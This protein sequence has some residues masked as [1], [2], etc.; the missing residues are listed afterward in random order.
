MTD[1]LKV[2]IIDDDEVDRLS[3]AR[4][5]K[6]ADLSIALVQARS[7]SEGLAAAAR[8]RFDVILLDF[9]LPDQDGLEVL[10]ILRETIDKNAT[11]L[12]LSNME[13][14]ELVQKAIDAGAQD[15]LL[16]D[17]VTTRRLM[18]AVRQSQHRRRLEE[19]LSRVR[20]DLRELAEQDAL[21]GLANRYDFE[22]ALAFSVA[23]GQRD[24]G[25][26]A[27]L[28]LDV[29][30]FKTVND[31]FGHAVGDQLLIEVA[32]RLSTV[33]RDSDLLARLG[34]D[35]F[36]ILA[37]DME[38]DDQATLLAK[39]VVAC[40]TEPMVFGETTWTVTTSIGIAVFGDYTNNPSDLMR[41]ADI[42]MYRAKK[43]GRNQAH[44][45]SDQL[46]QNVLQ[47]TAL[48]RDLRIALEQQQFQIYYQAQ[49]NAKDGSLGGLE[50]L[51]R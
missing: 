13:D 51:L 45:Y 8:Q 22:R 42:A 27:V 50:A 39:R 47:Q 46:H 12:M 26:L 1:E 30:N 7:A 16:K 3:I 33:V 23:R 9:R 34:G 35:E 19:A 4:T 11:V 21:T 41:C 17:E 37:N 40:F 36:V 49:I 44:F 14:D 10:R 43:A 32:R 5:L 2:L 28:L 6:K 25:R 24:G 18:R 29:D 31:T 38:R 20:E 48:E 15:F